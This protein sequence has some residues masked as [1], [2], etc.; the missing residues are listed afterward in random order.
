MQ[1]VSVI[2]NAFSCMIC[3]LNGIFLGYLD[4]AC[5]VKIPLFLEK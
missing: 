5:G 2:D 3:I 1:K 4:W